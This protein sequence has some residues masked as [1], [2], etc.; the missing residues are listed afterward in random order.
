MSSGWLNVDILSDRT[1]AHACAST[2]LPKLAVCRQY[3]FSGEKARG[4][5][6]IPSH[7]VQRM[8]ARLHTRGAA[9][10]LALCA[11]PIFGFTVLMLAVTVWN[12]PPE[13]QEPAFYSEL[14]G[15]DLTGVTDDERVTLLKRLNVQRC[16]CGCMRT[17]AGCRNRHSSCSLS[18]G[19]ARAQAAALL[20]KVRRPGPA[21]RNSR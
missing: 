1:L 21:A 3:R 13:S 7:T 11:A 4:Q 12:Q 15:V 14:P 17:V 8:A 6:E 2:C 16:P 19:E 10:W 20:A 9:L 5:P 18:L